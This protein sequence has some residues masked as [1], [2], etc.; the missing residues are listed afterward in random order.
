MDVRHFG[1]WICYYPQGQQLK[2]RPQVH[3]PHHHLLLFFFFFFF[4][5]LGLWNMICSFGFC[6]SKLDLGALSLFLFFFPFSIGC[7]V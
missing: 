2:G 3:H 6:S 4:F 7:F 1:V 5:F